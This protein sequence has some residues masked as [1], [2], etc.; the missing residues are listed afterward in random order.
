M[1][2]SNPHQQPGHLNP[3]VNVFQPHL[4][5]KP[6][7]S[8]SLKRQITAQLVAPADILDYERPQK[9]QRELTSEGMDKRHPSSF[10]QLEKVCHYTP[11]PLRQL[12]D[13]YCSWEREPMRL[14]DSPQSSVACP[15][16]LTLYTI[17]LQRT[18]STDWRA[19]RSEGNPS[20]QRRRNT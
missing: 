18:Q 12:A 17:G 2:A 14:Y 20:R 6:S 1:N 5:H 8:S 19:G 7:Q 15:T 10:Q 3:Q 4:A 9:R 11:T 13:D 16:S